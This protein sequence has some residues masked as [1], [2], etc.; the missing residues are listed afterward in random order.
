MYNPFP[1]IGHHW[2]DST[3][4]SFGVL[5][6]GVYTGWAKLEGSIFHGREP[7][8]DRWTSTSVRSTRGRAACR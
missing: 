1:P 3:H 7:D 5:T 4:I 6:A 8:E 2:Q